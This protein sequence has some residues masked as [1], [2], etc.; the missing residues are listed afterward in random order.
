MDYIEKDGRLYMTQRLPGES[1]DIVYDKLW[2]MASIWKPD[3][4]EDDLRNKADLYINQKYYD[5]EYFSD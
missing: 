5:C 4:T 1:L 3:M 2:Y